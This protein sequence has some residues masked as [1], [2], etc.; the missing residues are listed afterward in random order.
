MTHTV[1]FF[2]V[3][4]S[5][6]AQIAEVKKYMTFLQVMVIF[7]RLLI[8]GLKIFSPKMLDGGGGTFIK[9][10]ITPKAKID[11]FQVF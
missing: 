6:F 11:S 8:G 9:I 10:K 3:L 4:C 7:S 1:F 5:L 2:F